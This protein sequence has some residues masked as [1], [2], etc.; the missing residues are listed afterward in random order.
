MIFRYI[1]CKAL[2]AYFS[3]YV[4]VIWVTAVLLVNNLIVTDL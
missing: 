2:H 1:S 4:L 3:I